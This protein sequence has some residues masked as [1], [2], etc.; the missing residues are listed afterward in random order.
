MNQ[1]TCPECGKKFEPCY[2]QQVCCGY[3]C[4]NIRKAKLRG[5]R[6]NSHAVNQRKRRAEQKAKKKSEM[7]LRYERL[8]ARDA[9]YAGSPCAAPVTVE[10][11]G[12][13]VIETRGRAC[14]GWRSCG[15]VSHNG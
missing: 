10:E 4:A 5:L 1:R 9:D 15:H 2:K 6:M 8:A 3:S 14:L 7:E 11:R 13:L 12:N